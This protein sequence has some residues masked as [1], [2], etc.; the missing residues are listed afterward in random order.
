M[1]LPIFQWCFFPCCLEKRKRYN[2]V[3]FFMACY[4]FVF[5]V[6]EREREHACTIVRSLVHSF[7]RSFVPNFHDEWVS[8]YHSEKLSKIG[9]SFRYHHKLSSKIRQIPKMLYA[10]CTFT[11]VFFFGFRVQEREMFK[12]VYLKFVHGAAVFEKFLQQIHAV[13]V[14]RVFSLLTKITEKSQVQMIC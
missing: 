2:E 4:I 11:L 13:E 7:V 14:A 9:L 8:S 5:G 10:Q 1:L 12:N 3:E 6:Q